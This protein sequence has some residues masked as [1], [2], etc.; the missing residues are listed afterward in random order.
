MTIH[1]RN[2]LTLLPLGAFTTKAVAQGPVTA[3]P[4]APPTFSVDV[5]FVNIAFVVRDNNGK[6][7]PS[8]EKTDFEVFENKQKQDIRLFAREEKTPLTLGL[9]VDRSGSQDEYEQENIFAA[10]TFFRSI[11]RKQDRAFVV[12]FGSRIK[13]IQDL[14]S[15]LDE[16][17]RSLK[18]MRKDYD[19][20]PRLGPSISRTGG[21]AVI[22]AAY[23]AAVDKMKDISGRKAIIM[24]GDGRENAS[25]MEMVDLIDKLQSQDILFYGLDNGGRD[26]PTVRRDGNRM[27]MIADET[28]GRVFDTHKV[29]LR[30]AFEEIE[31]ELRTLYTLAY[32][33]SNPERDGGYR[34]IAIRTVAP[35]FTVRARPGYYAR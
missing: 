33:S 2:F 4:P 34:K 29:P 8:M 25:D 16:L 23:W 35:G 31:Q 19:K 6:L 22:D 28:G 30:K 3:D 17:E 12:A 13:L 32:A 1:R 18:R 26:T 15:S 9:I 24:I 7:A 27:P 5:P 10:V 11:L 20:A 21:S 14:T